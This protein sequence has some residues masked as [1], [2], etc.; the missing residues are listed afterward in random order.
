MEERRFTVH[1]DKDLYLKAKVF[2]VKNEISFK[3]F[4]NDAIKQKLE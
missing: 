4:L 3:Q 2:C 1:I